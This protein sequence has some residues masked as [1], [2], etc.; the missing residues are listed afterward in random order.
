MTDLKCGV[1][2]HQQL[3]TEEKLFCS[4]STDKNEEELGEFERKLRP[5]A[6]ETGSTDRAAQFEFL[7]DKKF[8]YK[9]YENNCLV[10][11]DEEP[12]HPI[13]QEAIDIGIKTALIMNCE[14]PD[15]IHTM[16]KTVIDGSNT[17]GFQRTAIIGLNGE[18]DTSKGKVRISDMEL[19]EESAGINKKKGNLSVYDLNRLGIPLIEVGTK[20]DIK[21]P[22][23]AK[24]VALKLG[25]ILR[26]TGK[27]KRGIGTIRQ[28]VNVS[29]P[30]GARTEIKGFQEVKK[31]DQ[32]I[33]NEMERQEKLIE[34]KE[35]LKEKTNKEDLNKV[36]INKVSSLFED[37]ENKIIQR[38]LQ[39]GGEIYCINLPGLSGLLE[40]KL[41]HNADKTLGKEL[42][43]YA[44]GEK[45]IIHTDENLA[46]YGLEKEFEA[47]RKELSSKENDLIVVVAGT[48]N[49]REAIE[50]VLE[51]AKKLLE[52]VP[53]ETRDANPDMTTSY[54][55]PLP[56]KAR[57]YPETDIPIYPV[58]EEKLDDLRA[59]LPETLEEKREKFKEELGE[60]LADQIIKSDRLDDYEELRENYNSKQVANL[61]INTLKSV[62]A[63]YSVDTSNLNKEE[64]EDIMNN[65]NSIPK[66]SLDQ[67]VQEKCKKPENEVEEIIESM[68]LEKASED[69]IEQTIEEIIE[70]KS[71]MIKEKGKRA[72]SPLMG[73]AMKELKDKADGQE[74]NQIL[75][76][77]IEKRMD[78]N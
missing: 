44:T 47:L 50:S 52:G 1:E 73:L 15:E 27:V 2:I 76:E 7:K 51:R 5:V 78:Q 63:K 3:D 58:R 31:I 71:D 34:I 41:Y 65:L 64:L 32:L 61:I 37:T 35:E 40:N 62:K 17:S 59:N 45:G 33:R 19:E 11:A 55:R 53:E 9:L 8:R 54:S 48:G 13:N 26:S 69:E 18:I 75:Q 36:E 49:G 74:V 77:K 29:I 6:G 24:E 67:V 12:P 23:H 43:E 10:E 38:S 21:N 30:K 70:K 4:C 66:A 68:G 22:E 39:Q 14:I 25:M 20:T 56:G 42:S 72:I 60:E 57:M 46:D 16:R 28:D